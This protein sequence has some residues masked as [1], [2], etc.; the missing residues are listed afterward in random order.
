MG[1]VLLAAMLAAGCG[2]PAPLLR[3]GEPPP[4]APSEILVVPAREMPAVL[5]PGGAKSKGGGA[6]RGA[7][8]A[9]GSCLLQLGNGCGAS[10]SMAG[11]CLVLVG[12]MCGV[13]SIGGAIYGVAAADPAAQVAREAQTLQQTLAGGGLQLALAEAAAAHGESVM[14]LPVRVDDGHAPADGALRLELKVTEV[15]LAGRSWVNDP[16]ALGVA[17]EGRLVRA[18]DGEVLRSGRYLVH[19]GGRKVSAWVADDGQAIREL[20]P[21]AYARLAAHV[22][23]QLVRLVDVPGATLGSSGFLSAAFG[24]APVA[25]RMTG[26]MAT[27][28]P[29]LADIFGEWPSVP[30]P[31]PELRWQPFPDAARLRAAPDLA[32]RI[33][34]VRYDLVIAR[35]EALAA[36]PVV[37]RR[38]GIPAPAHRV[39]VALVPGARY[40]W[41]VRASFRLDGQPRVGEWGTTS[42]IA[43]EQA[44]VPNRYSY[45]FAVAK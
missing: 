3:Q 19:V 26:T 4:A 39:E 2:M 36:G 12:A 23:D 28:A 24:P 45:R 1:P 38:E 43:R 17:A 9:G 18:A 25:P 40:Y 27:G 6:V 5:L 37:Y 29:L 42:A 32:E 10:G 34:E 22:F 15:G 33:S 31:H 30:G 13:A 41:S 16:L 21:G 7:A 44:V 20:L 8:G 11:A 35:E 14:A